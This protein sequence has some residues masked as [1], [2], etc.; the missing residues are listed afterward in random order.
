MPNISAIQK[1]G[2][3]AAIHNDITLFQAS[4]EALLRAQAAADDVAVLLARIE[5]SGPKDIKSVSLDL[6]LAYEEFHFDALMSVLS[7]CYRHGDFELA[8]KCT[9]DLVRTS[10]NPLASYEYCW[11]CEMAQSTANLDLI[12]NAGTRLRPEDRVY[13]EELALAFTH[14]STSFE[15]FQELS[16]VRTLA[17]LVLGRIPQSTIVE[18]FVKLKLPE[19][20][21]TSDSRL[22]TLGFLLFRIASL[23]HRNLPRLYA[24]AG[25]FGLLAGVALGAWQENGGIV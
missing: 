6:L 9:T 2:I 20:D 25:S 12:L 5:S 24:T 22:I 21:M 16:V 17:N 18:D 15:E 10:T 1:I 4:L 11:A 8:L 13:T 14:P 19:G 23:D 7:I 3:T